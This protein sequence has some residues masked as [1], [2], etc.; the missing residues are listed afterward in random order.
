LY[1]CSVVRQ[2]IVIARDSGAQYVGVDRWMAGFAESDRW[3]LTRRC[4]R[5]RPPRLAL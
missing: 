3:S 4:A 2:R 1:D 5:A